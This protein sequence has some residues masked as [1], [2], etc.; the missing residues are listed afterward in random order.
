MVGCIPEIYLLLEGG[1]TTFVFVDGTI[2]IGCPTTLFFLVLE[3][4]PLSN[5]TTWDGGSP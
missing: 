4:Y 2:T 1:I 5:E 3:T